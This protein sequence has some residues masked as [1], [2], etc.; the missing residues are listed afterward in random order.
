MTATF[1]NLRKNFAGS[2]VTATELKALVE[3]IS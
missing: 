2:A 1:A 3:Y